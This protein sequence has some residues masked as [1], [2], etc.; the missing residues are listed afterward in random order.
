MTY[1]P[2]RCKTLSLSC[3]IPVRS[4]TTFAFMLSAIIQG[5]NATAIMP[6][7]IATGGEPYR[8]LPQYSGCGTKVY[9]MT[10][11]SAAAI[12]QTAASDGNTRGLQPL[13]RLICGMGR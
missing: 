10:R 13:R 3:P 12:T 5:I 11:T 6:E 2:Q 7:R 4:D 1:A 8:M 9:R